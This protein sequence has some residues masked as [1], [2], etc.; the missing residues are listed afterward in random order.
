MSKTEI[1]IGTFLL[2]ATGL[3]SQ[4]AW[5]ESPPSRAC[6]QLAVNNSVVKSATT[7]AGQTCVVRGEILDSPT[8][9]IRF[10]VDLPAP[11]VWNT[12]LLMIGGGG[13]DG[14]VPTESPEGLWFAKVLG[15]DAAQ[16]NQ[17]V[18]VSSD[19]G[20]QG[21]GT[22]AMEDFSWVAANPTALRNHAFEA[23]HK[24]LH[25]AMDLSAQFYGKPPSRR[26]IA[27]GSNGGRA[28]LVAIQRYPMD[29]DGVLALEP[30]ISQEGF[31]ANLGPQMLQHIFA[32][33]GNWL[34]AAQVALY[35]KGE[36]AT[37]DQLDGLQDG[38]LGNATGCHYDGANLRCKPGQQPSD[39]CLTDGQLETVRRIQMD[40]NEAVTLADEWVGY[41]GFGRGGQ[42]SDW[43]A[44]LFG[45]SFAARNAADF[46]LADNIVKW[47]ITNDPNAS[48]MSHD[49]TQWAARYRSLSDE[50]DATNPD[51]SAFVAHGGKLIVWYGVSD[52]CV[53]YKQTARYLESVRAKLG[54]DASRQFLRFY[55]SPAT[56]HSMAGAG[57][58][59]EPLLTVLQTWVEH[60]KAPS[61]IVSTFAAESVKPGATRPLCEYPQYPRYRGSGDSTKAASFTCAE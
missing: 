31:A 16:M 60:G 41:K 6:Q 1:T 7:D 36:L 43:V 38:I 25:V 4:S 27:G 54:S 22:V 10:R 45:S 24:V 18:R 23:N 3:L 9:K 28:G 12:K 52:A 35:E 50:I 29:Y 51:L 14:Y 5:A 11:S 15:P 49:P 26:Y 17:F 34:N 21:R 2:L 40:K 59:T 48:V 13:F 61:P 30:A 53:T 39:A 55:L 46:A 58:S 57:A 32:D 42:S 37:C 56:G 44:Y 47:G 33:P 8:S 20:H 19:S